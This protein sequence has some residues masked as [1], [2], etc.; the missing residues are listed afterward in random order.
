M[1]VIFAGTPEFSVKTLEALIHSS[2]SVVAVY[3]QPDR[4]AGRGRQLTK[5]PVKQLAEFNHI[6]V[7]QPTTL[8]DPVEQQKLMDFKADVMVVVAYGLILP[9]PV[10]SAP[11]LGC[12]NI[13]ASLLPRFRGAAPIQRAI[14]AGDTET[15]ITIMQMDEG[16][17]TGAMLKKIYCPI[18]KTDTSATLHEKLAKLGAD[19]LIETLENLTTITPEPQDESKA[20]YAHKISKEEAEIDW[21]TSAKEL[22]QKIRAFDPWPVA[23]FKLGGRIY[24]GMASIQYRKTFWHSR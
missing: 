17:D 21:H 12:I 24:T 14:L 15:G 20:T 10:L 9:K 18:E 1:K 13:H 7:L 22:S 3:T 5:S 6:P 19:A 11:R 8:R 2:H 16:L 23:F 4:P